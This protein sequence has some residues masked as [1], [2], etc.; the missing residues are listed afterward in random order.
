MY[1]N[2]WE[3]SKGGPKMKPISEKERSLHGIALVIKYHRSKRNLTKRH[4][5]ISVFLCFQWKKKTST[6]PASSAETPNPP[7]HNAYFGCRK[8]SEFLLDEE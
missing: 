8:S 6:P 5:N 7:R 3:L 4:G 2:Q 1:N